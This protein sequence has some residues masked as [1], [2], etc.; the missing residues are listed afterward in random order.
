MNSRNMQ[1]ARVLSQACCFCVP[2]KKE[3]LTM[4]KGRKYLNG[5]FLITAAIGLLL[6]ACM[7]HVHFPADTDVSVSTSPEENFSYRKQLPKRSFKFSMPRHLG[8]QELLIAL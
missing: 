3:G 8:D 2:M 7:P 4:N 1:Q 5:L 6:V